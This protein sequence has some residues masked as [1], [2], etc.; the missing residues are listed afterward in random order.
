MATVAVAAVALCRES[1][2][3]L[4]QRRIVILGAGQMALAIARELRIAEAGE[5]VVVNRSW[6]HAQQLAKQFKVK[7]A[8]AESLW[9][10]VLWADAVISAASQRVL[11]TRD[12]LSV[13]LRERKNKRLVIVD[14]SVPR[15]VDPNVRALDGVSAHDLDDLCAMMDRQE[16]RRSMMPAA[17]R[18]V[19]EEAAGFRHKLLSESVLP[20]I[21]A[22]RERLEQICRQEMDQLKDQFGPFT[23]DQELALEALSSHISQ[24]I[25]AT[26]ARQLKELPGHPE[27]TA[28]IQ[29]LFQL[30]LCN[31]AAGA[32]A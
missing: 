5:I 9:E 19:A 1:L 4:R 32:E 20:T 21:S 30:E 7:A 22:M 28:A 12:D 29:R 16:G 31:S 14:V 15:T 8:H 11:M 10:Q 18:I 17:E 23:E 6:D 25:S 2:G 13:A 3:N 27:L 24:R 26:M